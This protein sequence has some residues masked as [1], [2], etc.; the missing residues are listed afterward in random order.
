MEK[1]N[2]WVKIWRKLV[3]PFEQFLPLFFLFFLLSTAAEFGYSIMQHDFKIAV[4]HAAHGILLSYLLSLIVGLFSNKAVR[5]AT[6][7]VFLVILT[8]VFFTDIVCIL[9]FNSDFSGDFISIVLGTDPSESS[10]FL[11][12]HFAGFVWGLLLTAVFFFLYFLGKRFGLSIAHKWTALPLVVVLL[13]LVTLNLKPQARERILVEK[14]SEGKVYA[15][16]HYVHS[17]PPDYSIYRK[18]AELDVVDRQ[19]DNIVVI[20]GE[21]HCR[22]HSQFNGYDKVTM[23]EVQGMIDNGS[24]TVFDQVTSPGVNTVESFKSMMS[25]YRPEYGDSVM[26]YT[27]QTLPQVIRD[28]G[29]HSTWISNQSQYGMFDNVIGHFAALCDT[30]IFIGDRFSGNVRKNLDGELL[31]YVESAVA[32]ADGV[33]NFYA[34]HLMG[35]HPNFQE[36]YPESFTFFTPEEYSD[37]IE[38]Q[39][40][41]FAYYDNSIRYTDY[42]VSQIIRVFE[43][44]EAIILYLSDHGLDF[45]FTRDDYFA[46]GV[47]TFPPSVE[48]AS[49]VPCFVYTS[50]AYKMDFPDLCVRM[51]EH[52]G[53]PYR[54]DNLLYT[55]MDMAGVQFKDPAENGPSLFGKR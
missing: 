48:P 10:E 42:V 30:T 7:I 15:F 41:N 13:S 52:T 17:I 14:S 35:S 23:P 31:P 5:M 37:R 33:K 36:R 50:E 25:T 21:S 16:F 53:D 32:H 45:Y 51:K 46:H 8:I 38:S 2:L 1:N 34:I 44:K 28:A 24:I 19:P 43:D 54:M 29:Y 22:T 55:L 27:C 49:E 6:A 12:T 20:F 39:R 40:Q 11:R 47:A 18:P 4:L 9:E 3:L 26:F